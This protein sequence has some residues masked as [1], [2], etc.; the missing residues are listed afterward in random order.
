MQTKF[1]KVP[2]YT[3][4]MFLL[5]KLRFLLARFH[6]GLMSKCETHLSCARFDRNRSIENAKQRRIKERP[7]HRGPLIHP[8]IVASSSSMYRTTPTVGT[9]RMIRRSVMKAG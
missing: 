7:I 3:S 5:N 9:C 2:D 8:I 4:I 1:T 6:T